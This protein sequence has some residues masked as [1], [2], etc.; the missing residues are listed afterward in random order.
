MKKKQ[1]SQL[2]PLNFFYFHL[3]FPLLNQCL[4]KKYSFARFCNCMRGQKEQLK[5]ASECGRTEERE[6]NSG[7]SIK[8]ITFAVFFIGA[9]NGGRNE[10]KKRRCP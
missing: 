3:F 6:K 4:F 2:Q 5:L 1:Q 9:K 10:K 7:Q 8:R